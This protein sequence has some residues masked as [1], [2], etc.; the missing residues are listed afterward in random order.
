MERD[1]QHAAFSSSV[2][3]SFLPRSEPPF[4]LSLG[5]SSLRRF[6]RLVAPW[7]VWE[8]FVGCVLHCVVRHAYS[9]PQDVYV[10]VEFG[11][12]KMFSGVQTL[13]S[14]HG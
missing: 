6:Q 10:W 4:D 3:K 2:F 7:G 1:S 9:P 8:G 13:R 14:R 5:V 11:L 12:K